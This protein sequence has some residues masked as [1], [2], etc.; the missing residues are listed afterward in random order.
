MQSVDE[1]PSGGV[2]VYDPLDHPIDWLAERCSRVTL[3][4]P[5]YA[6]GR[7]RQKIPPAE[8]IDKA[9]GHDV[10]LGASGAAVTRGVMEAIPT[11][12][13]VCKLG[14]GYEVVDV[15]AATELG[16]VVTNTPVHGE[17]G[18][19]A[20]HAVALMLSALKRLSF[21]TPEYLQSGGWK[22]PEKM[23]GLIE[24][25]VVGI[26]GFG[27]IG[28]AVAR[29]L[30]GWNCKIVVSDPALDKA[31]EGIE[32]MSLDDLLVLADVVTVHMPGL[33]PGQATL[34]DR[35][36]LKLL[37][38][39]AVI[40]NTA[41]GNLIDETALAEALHGNRLGG[42]SLDVYSPEPPLPGSAILTAPN[43]TLTPHMAA[44]NPKVRLEMVEMAF[45]DIADFLSGRIPSHIINP[46]VLEGRR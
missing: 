42:A 36:R 27:Q 45:E 39:S 13:M 40:V 26:I 23:S 31:P 22:D 21:Y 20:E 11:L 16:I 37:K 15:D 25:A 14:I 1:N 7:S 24:G 44:W 12:R 3:G 6:S 17:I 4:A 9:Q 18:P 19:V 28:Q 41:R 32:L 38:P 34:I 29:R 43:V 30:G 10:L 33:K 2:F 5:L 8:L 35:E 46:S